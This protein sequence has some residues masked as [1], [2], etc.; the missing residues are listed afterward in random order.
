MKKKIDIKYSFYRS[1]YAAIILLLLFSSCTE[2]NQETG[3]V[4]GRIMPERDFIAILSDIY[5]TDGLLMVSQVR[6]Q[7]PH[8]DSL[9]VYIDAIKNRGYTK[10]DMDATLEHYFLDKPKRL[11]R[12]FDKMLGQFTE[13]D[14]RLSNN[15]AEIEAVNN[16]W[17]GLSQYDFPDSSNMENPEFSIP[18]KVQAYFSLTFTVTVYPYDQ[19][20]NP[21]FTAWY[22]NADSVETGKKYFLPP[23]KYIKDGLPHTYNFN[24]VTLKNFPVVL[25]GTL[26][27]MENNPSEGLRYGRIENIQLI[28][29]GGI[30]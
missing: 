21:G 15:P 8:K 2:K 13:M 11:I 17:K 3:P 20:Q 7:F 28:T 18:L 27:D 14:T 10:E 19:T 1:V 29:S 24:E 16:E 6:N 9:D 22:V 30:V 5:L 12:I 25:K 26:Y 4:Q 23:V